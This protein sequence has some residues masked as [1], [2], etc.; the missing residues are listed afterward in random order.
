MF[1]LFVKSYLIR[2][3]NNNQIACLLSTFLLLNPKFVIY[4]LSLLEKILEL[5]NFQWLILYKLLAQVLVILLK[6]AIL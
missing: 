4:F 6:C 3:Q 1:S 5:I 2:I